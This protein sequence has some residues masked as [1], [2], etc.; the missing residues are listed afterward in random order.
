MRGG[1]A[2]NTVARR[3][4]AFI[5][6]CL[7]GLAA[8]AAGARAPALPVFSLTAP[9]GREV[10]STALWSQGRWLIVY[11]A[12]DCPP[13]ER[14]LRALAAWHLPLAGRAAVIVRGPADEAR[15][16]VGA[17][18]PEEAGVAWYADPGGAAA[19]ALRLDWNLAVAGVEAGEIHWLLTGVL[20]DP[21]AVERAVRRWIE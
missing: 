4:S 8:P 21:A 18:F 10:A 16:L 15:R 11:V 12:P 2:P 3:S 17:A 9:D 1:S 19:A 20:N 7:L 6:A 14:L 13:C 5:L